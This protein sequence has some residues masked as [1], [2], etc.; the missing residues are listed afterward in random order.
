MS[1]E[2]NEKEVYTNNFKIEKNIICY[3]ESLI[4]ISNISQVSIEPVPAKKFHLESILALMMG[5]YLYMEVDWG[6]N[7][8]LILAVVAFAYISWYLLFNIA[9]SKKYLHLFLNS[10]QACYFI[11]DDEV[12]LEH[13]VKVIKYCMNNRSNNN[14]V[15]IDF[16]NCKIYNSPIIAGN[17]NEV[18]Q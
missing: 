2:N 18:N 3:D 12:F 10:G 8:G 5:A 4:Q 14:K 16:A 7:I 17:G 11:C 13:V 15:K 9:S 1:R 6:K